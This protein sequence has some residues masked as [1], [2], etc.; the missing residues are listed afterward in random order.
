MYDPTYIADLAQF[1]KETLDS[2]P[3]SPALDGPLSDLG[4]QLANQGIKALLPAPADNVQTADEI[5]QAI[6]NSQLKLQEDAL[7]DQVAKEKI[8]Q[9]TTLFT[10]I[11]AFITQTGNNIALR[12]LIFETMGTA[13]IDDWS[14]S[15]SSISSCWR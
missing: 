3:D 15:Y 11:K 10:N 2:S 8:Q 6:T 12:R 14:Q 7:A 5:N 13:R 1:V 9:E 4:G